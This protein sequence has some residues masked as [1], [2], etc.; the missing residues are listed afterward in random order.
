MSGPIVVLAGSNK[1]QPQDLAVQ[2]LP[3]CTCLLCCVSESD[4]QFRLLPPATMKRKRKPD[5]VPPA[6]PDARAEG[7]DSEEDELPQLGAAEAYSVLLG[8]LEQGLQ[9]ELPSAGRKRQIK[10]ALPGDGNTA[11][12]VSPPA[13]RIAE[14]DAA[15]Q[16][17]QQDDE[18][19]AAVP[20]FF[21]QHFNTVLTEEQLL[22]LSAAK[23]SLKQAAQRPVDQAWPEAA[24]MTTDGHALPE[25][26]ILTALTT[27][28]QQATLG[29]M[30]LPEL[31]STILYSKSSLPGL[32][33]FVNS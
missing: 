7:S 20:D 9:S 5:Q 10:H 24:W 32:R 4:K 30:L 11:K 8:A 3:L 2:R 21:S 22:S 28:D 16:L 17:P 1:G 29:S 23:Q 19:E 15:G 18:P 12:A 6:T 33:S 31:Q 27:H 26:H 25:V 13:P 14:L